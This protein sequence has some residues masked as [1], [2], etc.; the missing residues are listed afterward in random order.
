MLLVFRGL[1]GQER[2]K[3]VKK[4]ERMRARGVKRSRVGRMGAGLFSI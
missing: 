3:K 4:R 2:R 1:F